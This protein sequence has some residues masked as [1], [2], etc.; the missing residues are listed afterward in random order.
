MKIKRCKTSGVIPREAKS[1]AI[2]ERELPDAWLGYSSLEFIIPGRTGYEIDLVV[3]THERVLLV[4]LKDWYGVVT[5]SRDVWFQNGAKRGRSPVFKLREAAREIKNRLEQRLQGKRQPPPYVDYLVVFTA[6][7]DTSQLSDEEKFYTVPLE[8]FVQIGDL[9]KYAKAFEPQK[10]GPS[11]LQLRSE[12]D[13]FFCGRDF[14]AQEAIF[15]GYRAR[16]ESIFVHRNSLFREYRAEDIR[17]PNFTALLRL[18]NLD[19]LPPELRTDDERARMATREKSALGY[20]RDRL[21]PE[22]ADGLALRLLISD[23]TQPVSTNYFEL[24]DLAKDQTRLDEFMERHRSKLTPDSRLRL[25]SI[26]LGKFAALHEAGLAHRDMGEHCVWVRQPNLVSL[27]GFATATFPSVETVGEYRRL[28]AAGD[29]E[30]PE[31][32]LS[33]GPGD[34]FR[35]DVFAMAAT[36]A[37]IAYG[38]ALPREEGIVKLPPVDVAPLVGAEHRAWLEKA[39]DLDP[40]ARQA[41]AR[42]LRQSFEEVLP[43]QTAE[44]VVESFDGH[45]TECIPYVT[46]PPTGSIRQARSSQYRSEAGGSVFVKVWNEINHQTASGNAVAVAA[47]LH[48]ASELQRRPVPGIAPVV[49]FGISR[50]G[51]FLVTALVQ[52]DALSGLPPYTPLERS[53]VVMSFVRSLAKT[54]EALHDRGLAHGDLKPEHVL[55]RGAKDLEPVVVDAI[56]FSA[57]G[58]LGNTAYSPPRRTA[59]SAQER[60][61]FAVAKIAVELLGKTSQPEQTTQ[62]REALLRRIAEDAPPL[63]SVSEIVRMFAPAAADVRPSWLID[64]TIP[65]V[66]DHDFLLDGEE[67]LVTLKNDRKRPGGFRVGLHGLEET[68]TLFWHPNDA[69]VTRVVVYPLFDHRRRGLAKHAIRLAIPARLRIRSKP[70]AGVSAELAA[71]VKDAHAEW[72]TRHPGGELASSP[73]SSVANELPPAPPDARPRAEPAPAK[74]ASIRPEAGALP[75]VQ[76]VW[77]TLVEAEAQALPYVT[78]GGEPVQKEGFVAVPVQ[79]GPRP[80]EFAVDEGVHVFVRTGEAEDRKIGTL[81]VRNTIA[82][83]IALKPRGRRLHLKPGHKLVFRGVRDHESFQRRSRAVDRIVGRR[84]EIPELLSYFDGGGAPAPERFEHSIERGALE[85]YGLNSVQLEAFEK[86]LTHGPVA[87]LQGPPGTGKTRFIGALVHFLVTHRLARNVLFVGQS[88]VAVNSGAEQIIDFLEDSEFQALTRIG[89]PSQLSARLTPYHPDTLRLAYRE[90]FRANLLGR[91][92]GLSATLGAPPRFLEALVDIYMDLDALVKRASSAAGEDAAPAE[93]VARRV[94]VDKYSA[95]EDAPLP[96]LVSWAV[97]SAADTHHVRSPA[98]V[99]CAQDAVILAKE[100]IACLATTQNFD[101]FLTRTRPVVCGTCVGIGRSRLGIVGGQYDWVI[102]DEAARCNPGELA[103]P[104]QAGRRV[105]LVGD[106]RQLPP[107]YED[108]VLDGASASLGVRR[109]LLEQSDFERAFTSDYGKAVGSTLVTQY[110]MAPP[111]CKLVSDVFYKETPLETARGPA[112]AWHAALPAG[113]DAHAVWLD[114]SR[115]AGTTEM[116]AGQKS[117]VNNAELD[118]VLAVLKVLDGQAG[119]IDRLEERAG[120]EGPPVGVICMYSAQ[121]EALLRRF[122][123]SLVSPR[124]R[125]AVKIDTVDAYQGRQNVVVIVSLVR[126]NSRQEQGFLKQPERINVALS[127]AQDKLVI[128]GAAEMWSRRNTSTPLGQVLQLMREDTATDN[129][130]IVNARE[131]LQ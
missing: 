36:L 109:E 15:A 29:G 12:F 112:E 111:I 35:R 128:V 11:L 91:V 67:V 126:N 104:L 8:R 125:R 83:W 20:L 93:A 99:K 97:A 41:D 81:D 118:A 23:D 51:L 131:L 84:A 52:G 60:D 39:L 74:P 9:T 101:E 32:V 120:G 86:V 127:R 25:M 44:P 69:E 80:L 70:L 42:A 31:D 105:L 13:T 19:Q 22:T 21:A 49:D 114:T 58:R 96:E 115:V 5:T 108:D 82:G 66:T 124:L 45:K 95:S 117:Y 78:V 119:Y 59:V 85:A 113:L 4:D 3:V 62:L 48:A 73:L 57:G 76:K 123:R 87:L 33:D 94:A 100:W 89:Q 75:P 24:Y 14:K 65:E 2:I 18:W 10:P 40:S 116:S 7:C 102:V 107:M 106:H 121:R 129:F 103:V 55:V 79:D 130:R 63:K 43:E 50:V 54:M 53:E 1:L 26:L 34:P 61:C 38:D 98:I 110:R 72:T 90:V 30:L 122:A 47:F 64:S 92:R 17:D 71:A 27:S 88:H 6:Q 37:R 46:Y 68:V 16:G 56:D 28:L 77:A